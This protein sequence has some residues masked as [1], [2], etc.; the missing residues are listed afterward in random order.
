M[1]GFASFLVEVVAGFSLVVGLV[2]WVH[3]DEKLCLVF[4]LMS[5]YN[6]LIVLEALS[7]MVEPF[8]VIPL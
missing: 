3:H 7:L 8:Y 2:P 4:L 1:E 5:V 6:L